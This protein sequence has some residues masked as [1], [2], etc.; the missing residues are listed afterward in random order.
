MVSRHIV[1]ARIFYGEHTPLRIKSEKTGRRILSQ[2]PLRI[3][4]IKVFLLAAGHGDD[5]LSIVAARP[6]A[7]VTP[8]YNRIPP[9]LRPG[10]KDLALP[11]LHRAHV[12]RNGIFLRAMSS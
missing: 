8:T 4:G 9:T 5:R 10:S 6:N 1:S 2:H 3:L 7:N 12:D 11:T